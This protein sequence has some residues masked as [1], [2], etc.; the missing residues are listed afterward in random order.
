MGIYNHRVENFIS[1]F[2]I[3]TFMGTIEESESDLQDEN[4]NIHTHRW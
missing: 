4:S 2:L 3:D 1:F